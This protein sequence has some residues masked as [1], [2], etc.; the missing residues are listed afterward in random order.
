[1]R[2]LLVVLVLSGLFQTVSAQTTVM[3]RVI[4]TLEKKNLQ[5]VVISLLQKSDST[6]FS[7]S[8]TNKN[9]EFHIS[10][11]APGSYIM[12]VTYPKF[13][14]FADVV[15]IKDQPVNDLG[16]IPLTLKA[17]LLD[18]VIVRSSG[19]IRIK[20]D[21]TEF[22]A[23]SFKVKEGA[24]VEDL[25]KKL[26]G[27]QVNSKGEIT[28][29][30]QKVQKVLVDGEEFF[31]DDPT[32]ATQNIGARSV[33]KVQVFDTK[34]DQQNITGI[35]TGTE[36]KTVNIKLK[37]DAK[38]GAF[39]KGHF[40][41]DFN[42]LIDAK[43]LYNKFVGKKKLSVYGTK[44]DISTGSLNWEDKQK[45]GMEN[46][47]EYDEISGYY[48]S[49]GSNDE[50]ND[51]SLRGLPNSYTGGALFSNKWNEDK[52]NV[53][54]SYRYNRLGTVNTASTLTQNIFENAVTYKN[55]YQNTNGLNQQ[56]VASGKYE[57]KLDSL[58]SFKFVT[59][60]TYKKTDLYSDAYSEYINDKGNY[61]YKSNQLIDNHTEKRQA[62][63]QLT[64][65]QMFKK[66]NRILIAILRYGYIEDD[67]N[68]I[69]KTNT[70]YY[71]DN[72]NI[73]SSDIADQQKLRDG[74]SKTIGTKIT[75]SEP[76]SKNWSVAFD[77]GY[78]KNDATSNRNTYDKDPSG[79][80]EDHDQLYSNNFDLDVSSNSGSAIFRYTDKKIRAAFG[81]G[82]A[83]V[84]LK[85]FDVDRN[86]HNQYYFLNLTPQLSMGYTFAPQTRLS[87]NYRGTTRQPSLDQLQPIR[88][89]TDRQNVII[90]NPNLKVG[91]NHNINLG[92]NTYKMLSQK[93][94][95]TNFSFNIPVNAITSF[96]LLDISS[97][98]QTYRPVNVNGNYN[99]NFW[100]DYFKD[101]GEGKLGYSIN[102]SGNGGRN[103]NFNNGQKNATNYWNANLEFGLRL[104]KEDKYSFEV[105]PHV[106]YNTT[107]NSLQ[108]ELINNFWNYGGDVESRITF[109]KK[110]E[111]STDVEVDLRQ[112]LGAFE[113]NPNQTVW[114]ASL[115]RKVFKDNSGKI[116]LIANDILDQRKGFNRNITSNFVSEE[117]YSRISRY[118]FLK[119][120]WS[121]NKMPGQEKK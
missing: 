34:T 40:G 11:V 5:N 91:F 97:G 17:A 72:G 103:M 79:K 67:Q 21:T 101:G 82:I 93:G 19:G 75:W 74:V 51:W 30:G 100:S 52:H 20:G 31:G 49:F 94:I 39:G 102:A 84:K 80:Y 112:Q 99:W 110:F 68:A 16:P 59:A 92:F 14:D 105:G 38:K 55:K 13:A 81:S 107:K 61:G 113:G 37:E 85:L 15:E 47:F 44:S 46:D 48:Y 24:T 108:P 117:R 29:Q 56:H 9:G 69:I 8:R 114:N 71:D 64:Y 54:G 76:L 12:L 88:D 118:F 36:G 28:T 87:L 33:D 45:L 2:K 10:N 18:A 43:A 89:N 111:F 63:N 115:S 32:M 27:F 77:Y 53:N 41:T 60:L 119:F 42:K 70:D 57:W 90:G 50:F 78:N 1:M 106:G 121:F 96:N 120:E 6:L 98:K 116:F 23:D 26:P 35:S 62:E 4:D 73:D 25:L 95:F 86:T 3:G 83:A 109:A 7:F 58:T 66:P 65:R 22:I 104:N